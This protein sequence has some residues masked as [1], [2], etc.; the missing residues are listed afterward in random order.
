MARAVA[1]RFTDTVRIGYS[2]FAADDDEQQPQDIMIKPRERPHGWI[3]SLSY[4]A[5]LDHRE[6]LWEGKAIPSTVKL[7][8]LS[9][10]D[11][12]KGH[13]GAIGRIADWT[14]SKSG[15][16]VSASMTGGLGT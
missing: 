4:E 16:P 1:R 2:K 9:E 3:L 5:Y 7:E 14:R 11:L 15:Q 12:F 13:V 10:T 6:R 8:V